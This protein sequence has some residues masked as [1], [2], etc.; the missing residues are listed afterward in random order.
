MSTLVLLLLCL[1]FGVLLQRVKGMPKDPHVILNIIILHIPL[2]SLILISV[3]NLVLDEKLISLV[4]VAWII[5]GLSYGFFSFV[6]HKLH[7]DRKLI[8]CLIL[9]AGL[10]NTAFVGFPVI[11]A[12]Y[13]SGALKYAVLID[14]PGTFL[15]CSSLGLWLVTH[16]SQE[17]LR[18][19]ELAFRILTFPPFVAFALSLL[20]ILISTKPSGMTE[21]I[22]QRLTSLLAPLALISVGLQ[23]KAKE[24]QHDWKFLAWGLG[25]KLV[26]APICI[27]CLYSF[28]NIPRDIF[29]IV[30]MEAA[31]APMITSAILAATYGLHP[32]LAGLMIGV[33]VPL[34]FLTLT[35]WYFFL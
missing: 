17:N 10:G 33:G 35:A 32:R 27:F 19:R 31:M 12:L 18:K 1:V 13:G 28:I 23:L 11:E 2:P 14:Q 15:I 29:E 22:L 4:L 9:T 25:F 34:S 30:V 21:I 8:G 5:F 20:L 26:I 6:G 16:F 3:P 7:W 24:I